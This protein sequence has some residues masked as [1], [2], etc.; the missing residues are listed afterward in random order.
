MTSLPKQTNDSSEPVKDF[1]DTKT[2]QSTSIP[3]YFNISID[4]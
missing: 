1:F 3:Y 2:S 4:K